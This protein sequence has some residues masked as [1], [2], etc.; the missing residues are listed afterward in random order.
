MEVEGWLGKVS[1]NELLKPRLFYDRTSKATRLLNT[2]NFQIPDPLTATSYYRAVY[3]DGD[4]VFVTPQTMGDVA[5]IERYAKSCR[6][7]DGEIAEAGVYYGSTAR[8]ILR[9]FDGAN[10]TIHLFDT[11]DTMPDAGNG[12]IPAYWEPQRNLSVKFTKQIL[13]DY[14]KQGLVEFHEGLFK[15]TLPE[16]KGKRFCFVHI[17]CDLYD[18]AKDAT[19]FFYP[20]MVDG[21]VMLFHD[22]TA[23][24][25]PGVRRAVDEFFLSKDDF[26]AT[27]KYGGHHLVMKGVKRAY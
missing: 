23:E 11:F 5:Y 1:Y 6:N 10:K 2:G 22:Y 17:D 19:E 20:R 21:G 24:T 9:F 18:G 16:V 25:F 8:L 26:R 4:Y 15:D 7:L 12:D 3:R 27:N 13:E 14:Y